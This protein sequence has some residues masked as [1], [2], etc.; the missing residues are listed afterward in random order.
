MKIFMG[1]VFAGWIALWSVKAWRDWWPVWL[2]KLN[3]HTNSTYFGSQVLG[4][5]Y[6]HLH[7]QTGY[8]DSHSSY[9]VAW[10]RPVLVR[11]PQGVVS[12]IELTFAVMWKIQTAI[13][14]FYCSLAG[15][16]CFAFL[17]FPIT[18]I[19]SLLPLIGLTSDS[20]I[21]YHIWLGH[22]VMVLFTAHGVGYF[23]YWAS[24]NQLVKLIKWSKTHIAN[25]PG[26][27]ALLAGFALWATTL[28]RI[29]RR[30]FELFY[31]THQLYIAF[32]FFYALHVGMSTICQI[33]PGV[34]LFMVDRYLRFLQSRT[35]VQ[36][37]SA[38]LLP[39]E[40]IELNFSKRLRYNPLSTIFINVPSV[41]GLQWHPF[42]ISSNSNLEPQTLSVIIKKEGSWT[43]KL[44]RMLSSND[45]LNVSVEGPYSPI[46]ANFLSYKSLVMISGGSGITPFI[47]IIRE[48]IHQSNTHNI[49]TPN[50]VLICAFKNSRDLT[51]L[52]LLLPVGGNISDLSRLNLRIEAYITRENEAPGDNDQPMIR[53]ICP[54]HDPS[55]APIVAVLGPNS[56]FYLAMIISSSFIAFLLLLGITQRFYIYP[57]DK[58]TG[59]VYSRSTMTVLQLLFMCVCIIIACTIPFLKV[60]RENLKEA[61][62]IKALD[63]LTPTTS[64]S[65]W[66]HCSD[67]ELES[68][69]QESLVK[70]TNVHYGR[71]PNLKMILLAMEDKDVGVMASGPAGMRHKVA[72]V[73]S[74]G[75][76]DNLH[77]ESISFSW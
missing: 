2:P 24:T 67:K 35:K 52:D 4:S 54:K 36:L 75:I 28:P 18:R 51:M 70:A 8:K 16:L 60:K 30:K 42:T 10:K 3:D 64:P 77:F 61:K 6:R 48:F 13:V 11:G 23:V 15:H 68:L 25:V 58:N 43:Q 31:Y 45:A 19:S 72:A 41:S 46:S 49:A 76:A 73:C 27:L 40:G 63:V 74:S 22:I 17:F 5:I 34:Y 12:G 57:I 66:Y 38:R 20:S 7:A 37:V 29:R 56:W 47:S 32:V 33:L 26:E 50:L 14:G 21:K 65:S 69:P 53:T 1:L 55:Q 9:L 71:R 44:Y 59:K 39:S 62:Q